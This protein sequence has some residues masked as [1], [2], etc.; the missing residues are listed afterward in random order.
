MIS[1]E[2]QLPQCMVFTL[3][4]VAIYWCR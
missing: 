3:K 2:T 1:Q 4:F